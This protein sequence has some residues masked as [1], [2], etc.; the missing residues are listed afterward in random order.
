MK[1]HAIV[2]CRH[3]ITREQD[4]DEYIVP[5]VFKHLWRRNRK[6]SESDGSRYKVEL[7]H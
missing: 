2:C 6:G 5:N 4:S 3:E 7:L 1:A